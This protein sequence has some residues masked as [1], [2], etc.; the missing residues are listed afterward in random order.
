VDG[1]AGG[2]RLHKYPSLAGGRGKKGNCVVVYRRWMLRLL[3]QQALD[4]VAK[5]HFF[6]QQNKVVLCSNSFLAIRLTS[7]VGN[8]GLFWAASAMMIGNDNSSRYFVEQKQRRYAS[9]CFIQIEHENI[10]FVF[11][12][13]VP[14]L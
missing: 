5:M 9:N 4:W 10:Q 13:L 6:A 8:G 12:I 2:R 1:R 14:H 11:S 3:L 7:I